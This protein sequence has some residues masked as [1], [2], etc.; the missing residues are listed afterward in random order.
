MSFNS[1]ISLADQYASI[2]AAADD[3][4][5]ALDAIKA[6]IKAAGIERHIGVTCDVILALSEQRRVDNTMLKAFLTD[7]QIEACKKPILVERITIKPKGI[8]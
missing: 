2:K 3:A 6:Q 8:K 4:I 1:T 5:A 7:E